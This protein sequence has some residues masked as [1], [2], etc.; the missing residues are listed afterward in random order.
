MSIPWFL[1][2]LGGIISSL[3]PVLIVVYANRGKKSSDSSRFSRRKGN[4][5]DLLTQRVIDKADDIDQAGF[6]KSSLYLEL[7]P[8]FVEYININ[9][10]QHQRIFRLTV[11]IVIMGFS[12]IFIGVVISIQFELEGPALAII[13][14]GVITQ[15][16][17]TVVAFLYRSSISQTQQYFQNIRDALEQQYAFSILER[18][19]REVSDNKV[20]IPNAQAELFKARIEVIRLILRNNSNSEEM[21]YNETLE[22]G[23][24]TS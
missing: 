5:L 15:F 7:V 21:N 11:F 14:S 8:I 9:Q 3:L 12:L 10:E 6:D 1:L 2:W 19:E 13:T 22:N 20:T 23:E 16:V 24:E 4:N 17:A 18:F